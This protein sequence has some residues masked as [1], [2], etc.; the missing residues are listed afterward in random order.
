MPLLLKSFKQWCLNSEVSGSAPSGSVPENAPAVPMS[1]SP[2]NVEAPAG[3]VPSAGHAGGDGD[4]EDPGLAVPVTP[5]R[6]FVMVEPLSDAEA[7]VSRGQRTEDAKRQ[8]INRLKVE[9]EKR[10]SEVK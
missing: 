8:R 3:S 1:S 5:P 7:D 10:L 2:M 4:A 6:D 9:Y